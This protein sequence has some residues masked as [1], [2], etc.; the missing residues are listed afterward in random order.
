MKF[1]QLVSFLSAAAAISAAPVVE[2][3]SFGCLNTFTAQT[4]VNQY[5]SILENQTY[6]GSSPQQTA[7]QIIAP[8]YVEYSDSILSLEKAPVSRISLVR[9]RTSG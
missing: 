6:Y 8:N 3:R 1:F 5:I 9:C 4:I 2:E 7:N